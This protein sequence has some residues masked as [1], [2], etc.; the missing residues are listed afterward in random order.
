MTRVETG[1]IPRPWYRISD[2]S[3]IVYN[4]GAASQLVPRIF[5][6]KRPVNCFLRRG[7]LI[8]P[9]AKE[10]T[11]VRF[12]AQSQFDVMEP[13]PRALRGGFQY[14]GKYFCFIGI[15]GPIVVR[16]VLFRVILAK[17]TA[18]PI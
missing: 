6:Q 9:C 5:C 14:I 1:N 18:D 16:R 3:T 7:L 8:Q 13:S 17:Q 4:F 11:R 12:D 2:L 15:I 10:V